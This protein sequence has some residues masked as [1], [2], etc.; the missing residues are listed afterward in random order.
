MSFAKPEKKEEFSGHSLMCSAH[1]C[2]LKWSVQMEGNLCSYHAFEGF[3]K[4]PGITDRL[5]RF[6]PWSLRQKEETHTVKDMK[7]R[8]RGRLSSPN[9][10]G[11]SA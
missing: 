10:G 11:Q 8:L 1:G 3:N 7:T 9:I 2:P 6:G 5:Q 4:W